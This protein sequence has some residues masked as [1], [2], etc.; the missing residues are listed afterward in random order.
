MSTE[1]EIVA[2]FTREENPLTVA[3]IAAREGVSKPTIYL[4]LHRHDVPLRPRVKPAAEP[5]AAKV[6]QPR[7]LRDKAPGIGIKSQARA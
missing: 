3:Q 7:Q 5:K 6:R 2:M 1:S 4:I